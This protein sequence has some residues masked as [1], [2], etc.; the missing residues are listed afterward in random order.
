MMHA[1]RHLFEA[2]LRGFVQQNP[3]ID[4]RYSTQVTGLIFDTL[5]SSS[6][7]STSG[8]YNPEQYKARQYNS[9]QGGTHGLQLPGK[10]VVGVKLAGGQEVHADLVVVTTG[11]LN[12]VG[13]WLEGGG[14]PEAPES[15]VMAN[16]GYVCWWVA[17]GFC[18]SASRNLQ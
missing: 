15:A 5:S 12:K 18:A 10:R 7:S 2:V 11:R 8:Q 17:A 9:V 6:S 13:H 3:N 4:F 16:N 1:S 14:W